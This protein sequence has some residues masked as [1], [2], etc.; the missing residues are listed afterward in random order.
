[1]VHNY[2]L[3]RMLNRSITRWELVLLVINGVVGA[4]IFGLPSKVFAAVGP[5]S[6]LAFVV[7]AAC[8]F[9]II[10]CFAE[11]SSRFTETGGPYLYSLTAFGRFVGMQIGWLLF[12][13]RIVT[14]AALVNLWVTYCSFFSPWFATAQGRAISISVVT[15]TFS[16]INYLGVRQSTRANNILT[17]AKLLPLL[18]FVIVGSFFFNFENYQ[19]VVQPTTAT[20]SSTLLMLIFAFAG[21]ES[22][23]VN[24]GEVKSPQTNIPRALLL[25]TVIIALLYVSIQLICIG[26]LPSLASSERPLADAATQ[27]LGSK[28]GAFIAIGAIIS[29]SG[30]LN[31]IMLVGSRVPFAMSEQKQFPKVFQKVHAK[32]RTP[33]VGLFAYTAITLVASLYYSFITA[34]N[35]S[36]ISRVMLFAIVAAALIRLRQTKPKQE[37][38]FTVPY[39]QWIAALAIG[40]CIWLLSASTWH[41]MRDVLLAMTPGLLLYG[42]WY[43]QGKRQ[44]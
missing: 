8:V 35:F 38:V 25:G 20:F 11:V 7:C 22:V 6:M 44:A 39:G 16:V 4:G 19:T 27:M 36:S 12:L 5:L 42:W 40:I 31:A 24:A 29:I 34:V 33:F 30:T 2:Y 3:H 37:N 9:I 10:L 15:I 18:L 13:T 26:T 32:Y 1:M 23:L 43:V 17:I 14:F 21:F 41:E 28:A